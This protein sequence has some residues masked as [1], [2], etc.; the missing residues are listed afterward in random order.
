MKNTHFIMCFI[1]FYLLIND[2]HIIWFKQYLNFSLIS[3]IHFFHFTA[4]KLNCVVRIRISTETYLCSAIK[5]PVKNI[6]KIPYS[7]DPN[8]MDYTITA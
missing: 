3:V 8:L 2:I 5:D 4:D 1:I 6:M 7:P